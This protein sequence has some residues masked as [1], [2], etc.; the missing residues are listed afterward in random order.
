LSFKIKDKIIGLNKSCFIIAEAGINHNGDIKLA[1]KMIDVAVKANAD[2]IKFQTFVTKNIVSKNTPTA[3][4]QMQTTDISNQYDL[5][6]KLEL[7]FSEFKELKI[8]AENQDLIFLST[9]FD[10]DSVDFLELLNI[11]CYKISSGDLTNKQLLTKISSLGKPIILSTGMS[12]LD[13]I[14]E[15]IS[16]ISSKEHPIPLALLHC[17]SSYP[18]QIEDC[19]LKSISLLEEKFHLPVGFSDHTIDSVAAI[20]AVALNSCIIEKHFTLD[21]KMKGPDHSMSL[22]PNDLVEFVKSIRKAETSLGNKI[23]NCLKCEEEIREIARKSIVAKKDLSEGSIITKDSIAIKRP[24]T[25]IPPKFFDKLIGK[26]IL[27]KINKDDI[28]TLESV[29]SF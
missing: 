26:R 5:I 7:S 11:S 27:Q 6:K 9:P 17:V 14:K 8:Y 12:N 4:Y 15:A 2:A 23:K 22:D 20:T 13:E 29:E 10:L 3:K 18:A 28:L 1:K 25:G 19:N 24:G 16:W 21:K